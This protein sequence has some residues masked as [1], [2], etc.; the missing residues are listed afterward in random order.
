MNTTDATLSADPAAAAGIRGMTPRAAG[1][2]FD[3]LSPNAAAPVFRRSAAGGRN[4]ERGRPC[5]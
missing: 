3:A 5:W 4:S 2:P 1:A